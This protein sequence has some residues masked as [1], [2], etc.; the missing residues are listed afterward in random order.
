VVLDP[1]WFTPSRRRDDPWAMTL[2]E[3]QYRW[4]ASVLEAHVRQGLGDARV[5][6]LREGVNQKGSSTTNRAF[7]YSQA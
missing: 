3:E 4:L 5:D 1:F 6:Q 7:P 2:G